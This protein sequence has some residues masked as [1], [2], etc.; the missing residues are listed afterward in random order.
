MSF[1][2]EKKD[3]DGIRGRYGERE[4]SRLIK[5]MLREDCSCYIMY[6][7]EFW[8]LSTEY[9]VPSTVQSNNGGRVR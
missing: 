4:Y 5:I 2:E 9:L 8:V 1:Y 3:K 7:T 6:S